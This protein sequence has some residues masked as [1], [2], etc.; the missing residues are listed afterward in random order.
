[1]GDLTGS[2][3]ETQVAQ[4][5]EGLTWVRLLA[6]IVTPDASARFLR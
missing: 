5:C 6:M 2:A 1:V 4:G 3:V